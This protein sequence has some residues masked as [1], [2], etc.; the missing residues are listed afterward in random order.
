MDRA[1]HTRANTV[2]YLHNSQIMHRSHAH[3]HMSH[4]YYD[5]WLF[6]GK[7]NIPHSKLFQFDL[8][9]EFY[10]AYSGYMSGL[11][12]WCRAYWHGTWHTRNWCMLYCQGVWPTGMV[13][14]LCT[15]RTHG[16]LVGTWPTDSIGYVAYWLRLWSIYRAQHLVAANGACALM[17]GYI[18]NLAAYM[19][20]NFGSKLFPISSI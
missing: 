13:H 2:G 3:I 5:K 7:K 16:L 9:H 15:Q 19:Y 17:K 10:F 20:V 11:W 8:W 18:L 4:L 14:M 12:T 6:L 1:R